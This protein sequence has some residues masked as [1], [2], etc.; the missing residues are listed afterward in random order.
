MSDQVEGIEKRTVLGKEIR[1]IKLNQ[2][3]SV[4]LLPVDARHGRGFQAIDGAERDLEAPVQMAL[5]PDPDGCAA[6]QP[7]KDRAGPIKEPCLAE[8]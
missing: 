8:A 3:R 4:A 1:N 2:A 6:D 5:S 7:A